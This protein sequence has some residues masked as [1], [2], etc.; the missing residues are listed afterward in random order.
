MPQAFSAQARAHAVL[1]RRSYIGS[2]LT[3]TFSPRLVQ[4]G[5]ASLRW[6]GAGCHAEPAC[7]AFPG[8]PSPVTDA[9]GSSCLGLPFFL[10][11]DEQSLDQVVNALADSLSHLL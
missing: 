6:Y 10:D 4:A 9:L 1:A 11:L 5:I 2:P 3:L 8:H 7:E